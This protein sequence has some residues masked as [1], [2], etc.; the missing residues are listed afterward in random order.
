MK[1]V[2][3]NHAKIVPGNKINEIS[4]EIAACRGVEAESAEPLTKR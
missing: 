3:I 2:A 4:I 1:A